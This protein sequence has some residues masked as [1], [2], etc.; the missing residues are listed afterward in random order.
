MEVAYNRTQLGNQSGKL[1]QEDSEL[2][3]THSKTLSQKP[4]TRLGAVENPLFLNW[5]VEAR[6]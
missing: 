5:G 1:R 2:K 3:A 6:R 4:Q